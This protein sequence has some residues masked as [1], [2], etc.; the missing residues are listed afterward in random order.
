MY[1][2]IICMVKENERVI[3]K[4][5]GACHC[6]IQLHVKSLKVSMWHIYTY[7]ISC[8]CVEEQLWTTNGNFVHSSYNQIY[9]T[10]NFIHIYAKINNSNIYQQ[11][12]QIRANIETLVKKIGFHFW[13]RKKENWFFLVQYFFLD[14]NFFLVQ[15]VSSFM[16]STQWFSFTSSMVLETL[17]FFGFSSIKHT[18]Y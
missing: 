15:I 11:N 10:F 3:N 17:S 9:A 12:T 18:Q 8:I 1:R 4:C 5:G 16:S 7:R 2:K 6:F 14:K 13:E